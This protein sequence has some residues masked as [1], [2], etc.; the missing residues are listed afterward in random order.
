MTLEQMAAE[1]IPGWQ[2]RLR[3]LRNGAEWQREAIVAK[4]DEILEKRKATGLP[5][6]QTISFDE[7]FALLRDE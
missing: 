7:V 1:H 6:S 2:V 5:Y 4:L 3:L